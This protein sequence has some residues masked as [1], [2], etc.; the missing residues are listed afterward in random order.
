[1]H[2]PASVEI[3]SHRKLQYWACSPDT[4]DINLEVKGNDPLHLTYRTSWGHK[5]ENVTIPIKSGKPTVTVPI[6]AELAADSGNSGSLFI[7]LM[8]IEDAKGCVK[9]LAAHQVE[10][11]INRIVPTVRFAKADFIVLKEGESVDVPL[12][13][14]GH[15]P[16]DVTYT[17]NGKPQRAV[18][19]HNSNAPLKLSHKG[20][21][22]LTAVHD[23]HC[24]GKPDPADYTISYKVRPSAHLVESALVVKN[25]DVYRHKGL[26]EGER[27]AVGVRFDGASPFEIAYTH[28]Y[29]Q[30]DT[31][32]TLKS[33]QAV[34]VLQLNT[35][36]GRHSYLFHDVRD[37]NYER[38]PVRF[39]LEH[40][41][42][43]RP[44]ATFSK[45]NT[46]SLCR[47]TPLL[48]D[49]KLRLHGKPPFSVTLGVRRPASAEV[50][51][52]TVKLEKSEWDV[53]LSHVVV[54]DVGQWEISLMSIADASGCAHDIN[55]DAVLSTTLDVVETAR[56]VPIRHETDLCVGDTLDFL[57]QGKAPWIVEYEWDGKEYTVTSSAARFSREAVSPGIFK[58]TSVA[59]KDRTGAAQVST[60]PA[61]LLVAR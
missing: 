57:L 31:E 5:S 59:L 54:D 18:K 40:D 50:T 60:D 23:R 3:K 46:R 49:A 17:L 48:T 45:Q 58:I 6:P 29:K 11:E 22:Q 20:T 10:V 21:Y 61:I 41:V 13:L 42:H 52:H 14:T 55:D 53:D 38:T 1:M 16:W 37:A 47:D 51:P 2:P 30:K 28:A 7:T 12:R 36:P 35:D 15:G 32:R 43:T 8:G 25:G 4:V 33:A 39:R 27:D 26:C 56:V 44:W 19:L 9:R 34:G 24:S